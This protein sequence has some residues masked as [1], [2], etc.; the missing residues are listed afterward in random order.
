ML[1][2]MKINTTDYILDISDESGPAV[3]GTPINK[4]IAYFKFTDACG[5]PPLPGDV[6]VVQV[7]RFAVSLFSTTDVIDV[8]GV[9]NEKSSAAIP[10]PKNSRF[11]VFSSQLTD[12]GTLRIQFDKN[13]GSSESSGIL[14]VS[15]HRQST[16]AAYSR[17]YSVRL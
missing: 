10:E 14:D 9:T 13:P 15:I 11:Q 16:G 6:V 4:Q 12:D 2:S 5:N 1:I 17:T 8:D 3:G 7:Q